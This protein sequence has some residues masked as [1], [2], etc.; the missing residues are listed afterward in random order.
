[1][2]VKKKLVVDYLDD[3]EEILYAKRLEMA[4]EAHVDSNGTLLIRKVAKQYGVVQETLRDRINSVQTV[5]KENTSRQRLS[6][7]EEQII[8]RHIMQLEVWGWP[9]MISQV[10]KMAKELLITKGDLKEL[11]INQ[12][13][14]YLKRYPQLKSRFVPL[15]DKSRVILEDLD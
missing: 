13:Q 1:M 3:P 2:P 9:P 8:E 6:P 4:Q 11:R 12:T 10:Q 5:K 7:V 14:K 15:L